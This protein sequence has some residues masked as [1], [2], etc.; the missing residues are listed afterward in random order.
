MPSPRK[1]GLIGDIHAEDLLLER[2]IEA[3]LGH[4]VEQILAVGDVVDGQGD[5]NRCIELLER[6]GVLCVRGN[7]ERWIL[8]DSA[9]TL[10]H[11][12]RLDD[13]SPASRTYLRGLPATRTI[14]TAA[15][16]LLLCH[17]LGG[18][19]M[20]GVKPDDVARE[21]EQNDVLQELLLRRE[22]DLIVNGHTHKPMDRVV[23]GV[24]GGSARII[25]AGTLYREHEP[26]Y[27]VLDLDTPQAS[28]YPLE[29]TGL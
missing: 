2:A 20:V 7:H 6:H 8:N 13:L 4:G 27:V 28:F 16:V 9:R 1:L 10:P 19:D 12:H 24:R 22:F 15:G 21:L 3:L 14:A 17:G 29:T 18:N 25:N 26:C 5:V 11:A 23:R